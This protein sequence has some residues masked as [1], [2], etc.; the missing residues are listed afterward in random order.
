ML[1]YKILL[2]L[3][4]AL[5]F[6]FV[7][8][9]LKAMWPKKTKKSLALKM[10]CS[11]LFVSVGFLAVRIAGNSSD[12]AFLMMLGL[13]LGCIGDFFLHVSDKAA[14]LIVGSMSFLAGHIV[15]ICAFQW[16]MTEYMPE[17]S[18]FSPVEI[19]IIALFYVGFVS[20]SFYKRRDFG[21]MF[22]PVMLYAVVLITTFVK[23]SSLGM[24]LLGT[25]L[26]N[27]AIM[28][29]LIFSGGL[30]FFISDTLWSV[31]KFSRHKKNRPMKYVNIITY[32]AAQVL[33]AC[34]ILVVS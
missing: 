11:A 23:A 18:F 4:I 12:F 22:V 13:T 6:V 3:A 29:A 9:F 31:T 27:A 34:T 17:L 32:Y 28:S 24:R 15:Y 5:E 16:V 1:I 33:L 30:M 14:T 8:L 26:P 21:A 10:V 25:S 19:T 20:Y 7:P 2:A